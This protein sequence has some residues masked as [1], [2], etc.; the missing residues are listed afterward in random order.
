MIKAIVKSAEEI[1][2][3]EGMTAFAGADKKGYFTFL[4]AMNSIAGESII[5]TEIT[6]QS[7]CDEYDYSDSINGFKWRKEWLKDIYEEIDWSKVP[8]DA[9]VI[10]IDRTNYHFAA[11]KSGLVG[12]WKNGRTS[13]AA[14]NSKD[15]IFW[16][17]PEN[18][19]LA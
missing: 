4:P 2:G 12:V 8:V 5:L 13:W 1:T 7:S 14:K 11:Y 10:V 9:K 6:I 17:N 15:D 16:W 18:V 3:I 19:R